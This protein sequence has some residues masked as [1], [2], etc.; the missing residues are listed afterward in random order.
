MLTDL[1]QGSAF[2]TAHKLHA[3][4]PT[5]FN[6]SK[7]SEIIREADVIVSFDWVILA[8][9]LQA[10]HAPG[11]KPASKIIHISLDAAS[12]N[13]WSKDHFG[14]PPV[15]VFVTA[16]AD[17]SLSALVEGSK[18][19]DSRLSVPWDCDSDSVLPVART[20]S[21]SIY[22]SDLAASLYAEIKPE[23]MCLVRLPLG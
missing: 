12:H 18:S 11:V 4:P 23:D 15:D 2:P 17:K 14:Y 5:V 1:K 20:P 9:T 16:D 10:A 13:G 7:A 22:M 21:E 6:S 8:S 19:K 3:S